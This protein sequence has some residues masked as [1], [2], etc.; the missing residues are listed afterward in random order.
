MLSVDAVI[1]GAGVAGLACGS[2]LRQHGTS[3]VVLE[4]RDRVGGRIQTLRLPGVSPIELGAQVIHGERAATWDIVRAAK[5]RVE[6]IARPDNFVVRMAGEIRA[7]GD[8]ARAGMRAPWSIADE[9]T[10]RSDEDRAATEVLDHLGVRGRTRAMTLEWLAQTWAGDPA[11]LS[12]TGMRSRERQWRSGTGEFVVV[13]GYDTVPG[14]LAAGLDIRLNAP[15]TTVSWRHGWVRVVAAGETY[16]ARAAVITVPPGVVATGGLRCEPALPPEKQAAAT[17]LAPGDAISVVLHSAIPAP[18]SVWGLRVDDPGG[19]WRADSGS[20]IVRGWIKGPAASGARRRGT[21]LSWPAV[22]AEVFDWLRP[23]DVV[24][25]RVV[26][27]GI[28]PYA[29]GA[30]SYP[31]IGALD[32]ATRWARPAG[33]TLFFAGEATCGSRHAAMVQGAIES[34]V[35][36][37]D[38]LLA[39]VHKG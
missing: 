19:L 14:H 6:P 11:R 10:R 5:L 9:L 33:D 34:G 38:E 13:D 36:A 12:V 23:N 27:W 17:E 7:V 28:D 24:A 21:A 2:R 3:V 39:A 35:R 20:S 31:R 32:H 30:F 4:A 18:R 25:T 26:D 1:I 22:A 16:V 37:A 8:L 15:V 29:L